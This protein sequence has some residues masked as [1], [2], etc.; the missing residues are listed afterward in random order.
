MLSILEFVSDV[1]SF[2][3]MPVSVCVPMYESERTCAVVQIRVGVVCPW[4][5]RAAHPPTAEAGECGV[6]SFSV[7][8]VVSQ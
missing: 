6:V 7:G 4:E 1:L 8:P 5:S 3:S 2:N